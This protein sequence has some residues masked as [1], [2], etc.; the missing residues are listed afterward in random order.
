MEKGEGEGSDAKVEHELP[1]AVAHG[2][3]VGASGIVHGHNGV[4]VALEGAG[5]TGGIAM[6]NAEVDDDLTGGSG[7][8]SEVEVEQM[9]VAVLNG[10]RDA[11]SAEIGAIAT[12][13]QRR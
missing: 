9:C 7:F 10:M 4:A 8:G 13:G 1:N 5:N 6:G 2:V 3:D 12:Y 11:R